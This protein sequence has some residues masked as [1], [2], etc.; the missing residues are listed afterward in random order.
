MMNI[1]KYTIKYSPK[2]PQKVLNCKWC[3]CQLVKIM[4]V[5]FLKEMYVRYICIMK[6]DLLSLLY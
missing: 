1:I 6:L 3:Q 5:L 4:Y 2:I